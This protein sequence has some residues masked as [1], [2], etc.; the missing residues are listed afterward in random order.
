M[1]Q[2][3]FRH[4]LLSLPSLSKE[5]T[6]GGRYYALPNGS[7]VPSVTTVLG[8]AS[9]DSLKEWRKRVG[10][11][12]ANRISNKASTRG[13]KLHAVC[14]DYMHNREINLKTLNLETIDLF[15]SIQCHLNDIDDVYGI[16]LPLFSEHLGLAGTVDLIANYKGKR[17]IIDFKTSNRPKKEEWIKDYFMQTAI[18][19]VM[20]E[21]RTGI[22]VP[23]LVI[24]IA[25]DN[26]MAQV[27]TSKRDQWI[28][29]AKD[30]I[31][32][33]YDYHGLPHGRFA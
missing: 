1:K 16:E 17:S 6:E 28:N 32:T 9:K 19:A 15:S 12:E 21:E 11:E 13:T 7:K 30:V 29:K 23:N 3:T 10:E 8:W 27:F 24:I 33:Y 25:V 26:E 4:N 22:P 2:K 14:E 31:L 5:D 20:F 18:Y